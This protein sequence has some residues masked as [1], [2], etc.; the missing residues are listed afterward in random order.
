M[1]YIKSIGRNVSM[2]N[3]EKY[4]NIFTTVFSVDTSVLNEIFTI[5][6]IDKWDSIAHMA[7]IGQLEE[8]FDIMFETDDIIGFSSYTNGM[9]ILEKYGIKF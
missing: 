4:T 2:T 9:E 8:T 6:N 5:L 1:K 3:I 7:L